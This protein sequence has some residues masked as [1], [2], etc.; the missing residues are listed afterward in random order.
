MFCAVPEGVEVDEDY[1]CFE[2]VEAIYGLNQASRKQNKTFCEFVSSVGFQVS[3]FDP[4][5]YLK[6][7][8]EESVLLLNYVDDSRVIGNSTKMFAHTKNDLKARFRKYW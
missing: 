5:L 7:L 4:F 2:L 3:N 1:D 8:N 6:V